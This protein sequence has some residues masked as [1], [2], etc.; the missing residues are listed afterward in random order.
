MTILIDNFSIGVDEWTT[1]MGLV[2]FSV[3]V[4][5]LTYPLSTSGTHFIHNGIQVFTTLSGISNGYRAYYTT[6]NVVSSGTIDITIHAENENSEVVEQSYYLLYGY[7][8]SF[9]DLVDWG[10]HSTIVTDVKASNLVFC[11]NTTGESVFFETKDLDSYDL[12]AS[13]SVIESVDLGAQI[14]SQNSFFFYGRTY[15]VTVSGIKDF[16]NNEMEPIVFTFKI[17]NPND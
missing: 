16:S 12:G 10:P 17:E 2:T 4:V 11:P 1:A 9:N 15:T 3:D 14:F 13:I 5:D 6:D 7:H 8:V